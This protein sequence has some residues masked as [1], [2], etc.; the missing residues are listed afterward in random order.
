MGLGVPT[1]GVRGTDTRNVNI[2]YNVLTLR[3]VNSLYTRIY[4]WNHIRVLLLYKY[5]W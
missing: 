5:V 4:V 2:A 1:Y 3:C